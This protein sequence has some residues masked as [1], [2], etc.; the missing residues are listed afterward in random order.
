[1]FFGI[2]KLFVLIGNGYYTFRR[3]DRS[4]CFAQTNSNK[5]IAHRQEE[6]DEN[7]TAQYM[8]YTQIAFWIT[9]MQVILLL[10]SIKN[11]VVS[12]I[13]CFLLIPDFVLFIAL[14]VII[15]RRTSS[16]CLGEY[17]SDEE[18]E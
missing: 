4:D 9:A 3:V 2:F 13:L 8:I 10:P 5:P 11:P 14:N 12:S 1:M 7:V 6:S 15:W 18:V 16:V 17:L